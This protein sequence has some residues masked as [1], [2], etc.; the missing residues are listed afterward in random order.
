ASQNVQY[1]TVVERYGKTLNR[2]VAF[3]SGFNLK[4]GA[5]ASSTAPDDNNIICIGADP[6]DMAIAIN[7]LVANNGGQVVVD[8]GEVVEFLHLPIGG[9]V[10]DIDP[11]EMAAFEL[12]LDE[13]ARRL[14]CDLPWPF[15]YMFVLQI[16]AIPDYAMTDLGVV[17]CVNLRI[18]SPLAPDGPAKAKT[19]A[20]E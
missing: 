12:R 9:I 15:M 19:L 17:D 20:A 4:S 16:T 11:A 14:G 3:V 5:I 1:V 10:S 8:K 6:Q 13:A 7:H 2:P 18:I